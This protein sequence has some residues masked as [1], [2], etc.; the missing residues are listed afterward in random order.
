MK[1]LLLN[2]D[3]T[4]NTGKFWMDSSIKNKIVSFNPEEKTVHQLIKEICEAEYMSVTYNA[5]PKGNIYRDDK[6]GN[7]Y[8]IGY[9][10]RGKTEI[11]D[12]DMK[13]PQIAYFDI[14][15]TIHEVINFEFEVLE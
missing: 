5:Q 3:Y 15:V 4:D 7:S 13:K 8:I 9:M 2:I 10:Y 1:K 11:H 14:W 6:E 12:R